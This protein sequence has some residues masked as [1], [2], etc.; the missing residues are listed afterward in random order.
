MPE[1][2]D[3]RILPRFHPLRV[4]NSKSQARPHR[5]SPHRPFGLPINLASMSDACDVDDP[6]III[7]QV[8]NAI[9]TNPYSIPFYA[10]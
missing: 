6:L 10:L 4:L 9:V 5:S 1:G 8:N 3:G 2:D 7:D